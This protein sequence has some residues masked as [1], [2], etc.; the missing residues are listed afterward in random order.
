[1]HQPNTI[2]LSMQYVPIPPMGYTF[3][4]SQRERQRLFFNSLN[5]RIPNETLW[6]PIDLYHTTIVV[7]LPENCSTLLRKILEYL[8]ITHDETKLNVL[9]TYN[10]A[11]SYNVRGRNGLSQD[12]QGRWYE[13]LSPIQIL[14]GQEE[15]Q[16]QSSEDYNRHKKKK[17][18]GNRKEQLKRRRQRRR[19]QK[20]NSSICNNAGHTNEPLIIIRESDDN[21]FND[22]EY[23]HVG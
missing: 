12:T 6:T 13:L 18:R 7:V 15:Q 9:F 21:N 4:I 16:Q 17:C 19:Q 1:M 22:D 14:T 23:I 8:F 5:E 3:S 10:N 2:E 11:S 20:L